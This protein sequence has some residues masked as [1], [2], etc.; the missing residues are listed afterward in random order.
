MRQGGV[1]FPVP[2]TFSQ[3]GRG[4]MARAAL[5]AMA[6]AVNANLQQAE[7]VV[8]ESAADIALGGGMT[9]TSTFVR[10]MADVVGRPIRI[11]PISHVSALGAYLCASAAVG[12]YDSLEDAA[13]SIAGSCRAIEP[14]PLTH[15][16][17][18]DYYQTWLQ[19][20]KQLEGMPL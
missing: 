16:E 4:H 17:Y 8:G 18:V 6:Y 7:S 15:L 11:A 20:S 14:D 3:V 13:D 1:L 19:S 10:V 5:E 9:R 12:D 2:L